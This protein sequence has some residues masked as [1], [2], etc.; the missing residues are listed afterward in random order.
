LP[1]RREQVFRFGKRA[2]LVSVLALLMVLATMA[3][4][5]ADTK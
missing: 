4:A 5:H 3:A 2:A 1:E